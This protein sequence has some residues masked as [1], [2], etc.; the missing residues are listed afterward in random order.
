MTKPPPIKPC[1][2]P[3]S[4]TSAPHWKAPAGSTDCHFHINGPYDRYPLSPGRSY[5]PPEATVPDYQAMAR[6]I[7]IDRM[8]IVQPSTFGTDNSCTLDAVELLGRANSRAVVV[9]DDSVD[10]RT[11]AQMHERGARGVRF[12]AVSGNGTPLAQLETLAAKVAP[13]RWHIQ[14]YTHG[15]QIADLAPMIRKLPVTVVLDHMA[16]VQSDRGVNSPEFQAA[17]GLMQSGQAYVKISGYRSS[18]K[19]Y[20]YDDVTPMA[21]GYIEAAPDRCVWGT[22]WPHPSL[23]GETHMPDDGQ[24]FDMLGAWAPSD[25]LRRKILVENP[26][27]LYGFAP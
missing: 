9:I 24:L 21:R 5:S 20:P 7:G 25:E 3:R 10:E 12:N 26:A 6:T 2:P 13:L 18:V 4:V 27:R 23:F 16:G 11:L 1:L 19:G 14:F 15:D 8:V 22:D 17:V